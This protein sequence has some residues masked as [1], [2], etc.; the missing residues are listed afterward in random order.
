MKSGWTGLPCQMVEKWSCTA[1]PT[2][3]AD[4]AVCTP[5]LQIA[6]ARRDT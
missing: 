4:Y 2:A 5:I 6:K 1:E 3:I